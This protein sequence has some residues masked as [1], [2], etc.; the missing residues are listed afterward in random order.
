ME[1]IGS[2]LTA[3][4]NPALG[5]ADSFSDQLSC[6]Y[7]AFIL[8]TLSMLIATLYFVNTP[9]CC[10]CPAHFED[11]HERFTNKVMLMS[12]GVLYGILHVAFS[13]LRAST[14]LRFQNKDCGSSIR[15]LI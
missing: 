12:D 11:S 10:W 3:L 7:T 8:T 2:S 5:S 14:L 15:R 6:V 1:N 13:R 4:E 9:I